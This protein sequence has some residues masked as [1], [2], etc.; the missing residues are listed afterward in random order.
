MTVTLAEAMGW[1]GLFLWPFI[2]VGAMFM[3]APA[4]G[5][6]TLPARVRIL[7]AAVVT[8]AILPVIDG[9]P[10]ADP[11][12]AEAVFITVQ[13]VAIGI[14]MGFVFQLVLTALTLA[15]ESIAMSMGLGF[16]QAVD[17]Q[18]GV[19]VP[20]VSQFL[21]IFGTLIFLALDGHLMLVRLVAD[22][23]I[24]L[25]IGPV[26][27]DADVFWRMATW[28][29]QMYVNAVLVALPIGTAL[30]VVN[31]AMGVITRAAPQLHI[32]SIGFPATLMIGFLLL[33][34]AVPLMVPQIERFMHQG[35]LLTREILGG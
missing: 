21:V 22:S 11:F 23:F 7:M 34:F 17:P 1:V 5:T 20:I 16:A 10:Q 2:R 12:S 29:S 33:L 30:L 35:Y 31:I 18:N 15:G 28:G 6:R 9:V 13:Q 8:L 4:F 3:V 14:T 27:V 25:P 26:G 19:N 32:F 24:L